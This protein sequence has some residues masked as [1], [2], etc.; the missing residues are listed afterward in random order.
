MNKFLSFHLV[1]KPTTQITINLAGNWFIDYDFRCK[2]IYFSSM[3]TSNNHMLDYRNTD[4]TNAEF[5]YIAHQ[6]SQYLGDSMQS[7]KFLTTSFKTIR[8]VL[9]S[10]KD[11]NYDK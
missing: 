7:H 6:I 9:Q 10:R 11:K 5:G 8:E 4:I 2:V 3:V 1:D